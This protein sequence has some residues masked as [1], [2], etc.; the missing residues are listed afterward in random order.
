MHKQELWLGNYSS[1]YGLAV[2]LDSGDVNLLCARGV[3][4]SLRECY[5]R[6]VCIELKR[7]IY[8]IFYCVRFLGWLLVRVEIM[9]GCVC[10]WLPCSCAFC[11]CEMSRLKHC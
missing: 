7:I 11:V 10:G 4:I 5:M 9:L 1:N 2:L 6:D 3:R 8:I